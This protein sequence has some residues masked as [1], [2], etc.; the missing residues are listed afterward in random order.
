MSE[1]K[2]WACDRPLGATLDL[3]DAEVD[4]LHEHLMRTEQEA[5]PHIARHL[6]SILG[7]LPEHEILA[8]DPPAELRAELLKNRSVETEGNHDA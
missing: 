8:R 2:C 3:T 6:S 4:A 1:R 5:D 7:Q